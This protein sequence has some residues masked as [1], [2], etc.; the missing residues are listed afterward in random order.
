M[1]IPL[2]QDRRTNGQGQALEE[3]RAKETAAKAKAELIQIGLKAFFG[4]TAIGSQDERFS[5]ADHNV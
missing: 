2:A 3:S 4:Q 1:V 5:V